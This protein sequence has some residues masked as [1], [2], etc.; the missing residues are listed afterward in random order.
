MTKPH[1]TLI[2]KPTAEDIA[3]LYEKL[4]GRKV[5]PEEMQEMR[6][7]LEIIAAKRT[8]TTGPN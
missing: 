4:T 8:T 7:E 3:R 2:E 1:L 6:E 5:T